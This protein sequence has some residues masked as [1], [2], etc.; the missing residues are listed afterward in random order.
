M[1]NIIQTQD[2]RRAFID[3]LIEL[4]EKDEK[5]LFIIPDVGFNYAERFQQKFPDRFINTGV[6][7]MFAMIFA[8]G[9]AIDGWKPYI[10]SMINFMAFRPFEMVRNAV[11]MHNANVKILGVEGSSSYKFL[12]FSH[13]SIF[14]DE[15]IYHLSPYLDCY[16]PQSNEE[17]KKVILETY[18]KGTPV[19]IRL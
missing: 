19:Y 18:R 14:P 9:L 10:Y 2:K 5:I 15:E 3:I 13:N 17:V 4:A 12:G 11:V 8:A 7:E 16:V 6:N 1:P